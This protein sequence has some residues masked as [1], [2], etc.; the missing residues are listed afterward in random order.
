M[1]G[2]H[3][4]TGTVILRKRHKFVLEDRDGASMSIGLLK[5]LLPFRKARLSFDMSL[6]PDFR[7][8]VT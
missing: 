4:A 5:D 8:P 2:V 1:H 3:R 7:I 6:M